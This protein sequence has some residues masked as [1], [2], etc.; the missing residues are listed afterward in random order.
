MFAKALLRDSFV[1]K[2]GSVIKKK[3]RRNVEIQ[4][5]NN[6]LLKYLLYWKENDT[7]CIYIS[8]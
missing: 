5:E 7:L 3:G 1:F 2:L 6:M 8:S 4:L